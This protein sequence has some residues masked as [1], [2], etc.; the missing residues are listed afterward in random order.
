MLKAE[1]SPKTE[2]KSSEEAVMECLGRSGN[3]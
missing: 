3:T 1:E 2:H